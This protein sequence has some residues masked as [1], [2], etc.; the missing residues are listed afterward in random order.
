MARDRWWAMLVS[1]VLWALVAL[2]IGAIMFA[3]IYFGWIH[4][5]GSL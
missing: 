5:G 3:V 4:Q 1:G 2:V